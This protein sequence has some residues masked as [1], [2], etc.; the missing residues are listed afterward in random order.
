V[1]PD[2]AGEVELQVVRTV[3]EQIY[4]G[5]PRG[6]FRILEAYVRAL[7]S[8]QRLIY[9]EN[10][11]L[12][13]PELVQILS[14]KLRDPPSPAFR[15]VLLLPARPA[16]GGDDTRGQLGVLLEADRGRGRLAACSLYSR[17]HRDPHPIYVHA[18]V[19]I[20]DDHWLTVGSAN[21]NEHSLFNDSEV[22]LVICDPLLAR[23][24]RE[25]LWREHLDLTAEAAAKDPTELVDQVWQPMGR[26]QLRLLEA[27]QPLAHKLVRLPAVSR[28]SMRLL[29]PLQGLLVDG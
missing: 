26:E 12:W 9:V 29:G 15:V 28:R 27:H 3:P 24:T 2:P 6:D 19:A 23:R 1:V 21:L 4:G 16:R 5:L 20:V 10:Q 14:Q 13:S 11:F 7:R 25:L 17:G 22:N 18:K 8:A